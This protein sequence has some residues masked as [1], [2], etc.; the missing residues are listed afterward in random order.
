MTSAITRMSDLTD[1]QSRSRRDEQLAKLLCNTVPIAVSSICRSGTE[2]RP[3]ASW[4]V[5]CRRWASSNR[6][7]VP[8]L[9]CWP[10]VGLQ[11][12]EQKVCRLSNRKSRQSRQPCREPVT[13]KASTAPILGQNLRSAVGMY[14]VL[15][16]QDSRQSPKLHMAVRQ[17]LPEAS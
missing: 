6:S 2:E 17:V 1:H 14:K 8:H 11:I 3:R 5:P 4:T 12:D 16:C 9:T 15:N 10:R 7:A 13:S